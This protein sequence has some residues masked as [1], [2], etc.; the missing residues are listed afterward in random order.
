MPWAHSKRS[1]KMPERRW[2]RRAARRLARCATRP[3]DPSEIQK[4]IKF[5]KALAGVSPDAAAA[6][7][8]L[9]QR[10]GTVKT[11]EGANELRKWL[12]NELAPEFRKNAVAGR[13]QR[14]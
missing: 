10:L 3:F 7:E 12:N 1:R 4:A 6:I 8:E 9:R 14:R 13:T 11:L 5:P 2:T